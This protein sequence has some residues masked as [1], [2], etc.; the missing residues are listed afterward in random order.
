MVVRVQSGQSNTIELKGE[1]Q[2]GSYGNWSLQEE[3]LILEHCD[4]RCEGVD[5]V[6]CW[7]TRWNILWM[8]G[9]QAELEV[10]GGGLDNFNDEWN[11][12]PGHGVTNFHLCCENKKKLC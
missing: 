10:L 2:I 11:R 5:S 6:G 1:G 3:E 9:P 12:R 7:D 8:T 4:V